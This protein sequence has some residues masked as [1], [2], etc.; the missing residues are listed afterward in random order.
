M[1]SV[2]A[3]FFS[4]S[5]MRKVAYSAIIPT[6]NL[7]NKK[8]K[9]LYLLHGWN[10]NQYDWLHLGNI[11]QLAE[12]FKVAVVLPSGENSFYVNHPNGNQYG[13]FIGQELVEETRRLFP[14]SKKREDTWIAGLS[15]GGYGALRN[16]L[17]YHKTFGKV[18][19]LSSRVLTQDDNKAY[20]L[21]KNI[22]EHQFTVRSLVSGTDFKD[23]PDN[24]DIHKLLRSIKNKQYPE[25]FLACGTEDHLYKENKKLHSFLKAEK[26]SH[27][28]YEEKGNHNWEFWNKYIVRAFEWMTN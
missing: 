17:F 1:T 18:A 20:D 12:E 14:L 21:T 2:N 13:K 3:V 10:G 8:L 23:L 24:M 11:E 15:M 6:N 4:T 16:G 26:L 9:T 28:Y 22:P 7:K 5:L 27:L 19:A 25:L